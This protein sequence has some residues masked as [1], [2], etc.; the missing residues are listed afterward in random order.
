MRIQ[1]AIPEVR[2]TGTRS[3]GTL[4]VKC[5]LPDEGGA[6]QSVVPERANMRP[7]A[8]QYASARPVNRAVWRKSSTALVH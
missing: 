6:Q 4:M 2:T 7:L 3:S 1:V 5:R 8:F